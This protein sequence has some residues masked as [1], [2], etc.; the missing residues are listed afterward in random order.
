VVHSLCRIG[1][2]R[3]GIS[4][5][6]FFLGGEGVVFICQAKWKSRVKVGCS[7]AGLDLPQSVSTFSHPQI[8]RFQ[9]KT[10]DKGVVEIDTWEWLLFNGC[11][12]GRD[13]GHTQLGIFN[14]V[15]AA[16]VMTLPQSFCSIRASEIGAFPGLN[17]DVCE[18]RVGV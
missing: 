8:R 3:V 13:Q 18:R 11:L 7:Q 6:N 17:L 10:A 5:S 9:S 4:P 16:F 12:S 1:D 14:L 2:L 15:Q